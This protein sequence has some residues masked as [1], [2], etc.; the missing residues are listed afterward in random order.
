MI[1]SSEGNKPKSVD[2]LI[3]PALAAR[4]DRL[5]LASRTLLSGTMPG[6]RRSKRR[7]KSVE[8][9]DF[10]NYTP[11]DDLR[12]IDWNVYARLDR[13]FIKIFREEEDLA[14]HLLV[15]ASA[16]MDAG[17]GATNKL[18]FSARLAMALAYVGL[19]RQNRVSVAVL[20]GRR[21]E[22]PTRELVRQISPVRGRAGV[23]IVGRLLLD[24]LEGSS[25]ENRAFEAM[26][27]NEAVARSMLSRAGT[28]KRGV[29]VLLTDALQEGGVTRAINVLASAGA[30]GQRTD[31][32]FV[33]VLSPTEIDPAA[34]R[35]VDGGVGIG[36]MR[37]LLGDV[38]LTDVETGRAREVSITP[39]VLDAY[40]SRVRV[41]A[42]NL[43]RECS[44][45]GVAFIP[46]SSDASVEDLVLTTL[47][48]GG[49]LV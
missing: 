16:S 10:R 34:S 9:D 25:V 19:V 12:H 44:R 4:L 14:L 8:F 29:V 3:G 39:A 20:G 47:R 28:G 23:R 37:S 42:E 40:R 21:P 45:R 46:I 13:L 48:R 43:K 32:Y 15:D 38:R 36:R 11:G 24:A 1:V 30:G 7:G 17:E 26:D 5:D 6:E 18:V 41:H 33:R 22:A 49:M 2:E 31:G 35:S 27:L